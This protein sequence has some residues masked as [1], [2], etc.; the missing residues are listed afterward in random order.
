MKWLTKF[1]ILNCAEGKRKLIKINSGNLV[2][3]RRNYDISN[4]NKRQKKYLFRK[5][6]DVEKREG[7]TWACFNGLV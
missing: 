6:K 4:K 7:G 2:C 3:A 1:N 5:E